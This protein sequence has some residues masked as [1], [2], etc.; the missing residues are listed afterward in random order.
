[1]RIEDVGVVRM[2]EIYKEGQLNIFE[3]LLSSDEIGKK[4]VKVCA[5]C[6]SVNIKSLKISSKDVKGGL[7]KSNSTIFK[8]NIN[9]IIKNKVKWK[10]KS[11]E[12]I[13]EIKKAVEDDKK[14]EKTEE[15]RIESLKELVVKLLK[16][17]AVKMP[18]S[19][20]DAHLKW[21]DVD[22]IKELC[23]E[24]YHNGEI[25]RTGN[26]RYFILNEEK[27]K[28]EKASAPKSEAVDVEKELEKLKRLL[29]KGLITQEQYDAKSNELLGL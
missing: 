18:A 7:F 10:S 25:S 27:K 28:P 12:A 1:L 5:F 13:K 23:E 9:Q 20:I 21:Q 4:N 8:T 22:E 14:S 3:K 15:K 26:Y 6:F 16:E 24:M 19:D 11:I 2:D 17:K 29:N